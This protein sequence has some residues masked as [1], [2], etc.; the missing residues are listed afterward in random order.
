V[1]EEGG[2]EIKEEEADV[3]ESENR[4]FGADDVRFGSVVVE[5]TDGVTGLGT[6][7]PGPGPVDAAAV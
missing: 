7:S 4:G 1:G 6:E 2:G 3:L 5:D